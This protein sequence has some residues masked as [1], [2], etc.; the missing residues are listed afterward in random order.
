LKL[1]GLVPGK[2]KLKQNFIS[3]YIYTVFPVII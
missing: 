3:L 2:R 1:G